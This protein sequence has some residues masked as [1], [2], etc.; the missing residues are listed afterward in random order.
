[1]A[2]AF[3]RALGCPGDIARIEVDL[4]AGK[5]HAS[6]GQ[7]V[8]STGTEQI[9]LESSRYPF[10]FYGDGKSPGSTRSILP[11]LPFNAE[12]NRFTLV[13]SGASAAQYRI[14]WGAAAKEFTASHL[15]A[16]INLAAEFLENPFSQPFERVQAKIRAQQ[17]YETPLVKAF[18]HDFPEIQQAV[19]EEADALKRIGSRLLAKDQQLFAAAAA[20]VEPVRHTLKIEPVQ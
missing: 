17:S 19:P 4:V 7:R 8:L 6:E 18:L 11:A 20:A 12:L 2:F 10:C 5:V 3:L 16:G 15:S 14:T 13:V 1:M 9:E